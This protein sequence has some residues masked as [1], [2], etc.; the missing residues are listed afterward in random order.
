MGT[1]PPARRRRTVATRVLLSYA[2][3]SALFALVA[4]WG[5]FALRRSAEDADLMRSGYLPLSL[6]LRDVVANQDT[7]N[8]QLNHI[9]TAQNPADKRVWFETALRIGRPKMFEEVRASVRQAFASSSDASVRRVGGQL[10]VELDDI[11]R[12]LA[13]DREQ[14]TQLFDALSRGDTARAD[15]LRD[16]LVTRGSQGKRRLSQLEQ[17]VQQNVDALLDAARSRERLAVRLLAVLAALSFVMGLA[18]VLYTRRV[19]AP[20]GAVTHRAMAVARGDLTPREVVASPDEIGELAITFENMVSAIARA[21]E[22]LLAAERLATIGKMAAHVTHEIRNPLSSIALNVELLEEELGA[23]EAQQEARSLLRAIKSEVDR[24]T[25]L[26]EQYLSVA[27]QQPV[28]LEA[29][30]VAALVAE[31][32]EFVRR[33]LERHGVH[34]AIDV[35]EPVPTVMADEAQIKQALYNLLRNAREAMP[36][37]GRVRILVT[38]ANGGGV[39]VVVDDE[40]G[41]IDAETRERMFEPFFTTKS[42]GKGT[43]LGLAAVHGIVTAH[44]GAI[45]VE[46][47]IGK[48]TTFRILLPVAEQETVDETQATLPGSA[49]GRELVLLVDDEAEVAAMTARAL[50]RLGYEVASCEDPQDAL[51]TFAEDPDAWDIVVTDQTMPGLTGMELARQMLARRPTLPI[52]LCTGFSEATSQEAAF[53]IGIA[54]FLNKPVAPEKLAGTVRRL[55]D[56]RSRGADAETDPAVPARLDA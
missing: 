1:E 9:T 16:Q 12:L 38:A 53:A 5:V 25:A 26:S 33:D 41:G 4:G 22:Q 40:G 51:D 43:G 50:E 23:S 47:V 11:E 29:E 3:V 24:L 6:A 54:A 18:T 37:G 20:L 8:T 39:D 32:G 21:N 35:D 56:S 2:L 34:L 45:T 36:G 44:G 17:R 49:K 30:D 7:W 27:R 15:R 52:V 46:S 55:L 48:G 10:Q 19:L 14:L 31:A 42:V 28:R 13:R